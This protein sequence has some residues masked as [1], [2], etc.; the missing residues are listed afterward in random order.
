MRTPELKLRTFYTCIHVQ[1]Q[2]KRAQQ[3]NGDPAH[4][5]KADVPAAV[6]QRVER[7]RFHVIFLLNQGPAITA[8]LHGLEDLGW[9]TALESQ[10][11]TRSAFVVYYVTALLW[12]P[13]SMHAPTGKTHSWVPMCCQARH[14]VCLLLSTV[15]QP[16]QLTL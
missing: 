13:E 16:L 6:F 8:I 4:C 12:G 1:G 15:S 3:A 9:P 14:S 11:T 10:D 5:A 2:I 7:D